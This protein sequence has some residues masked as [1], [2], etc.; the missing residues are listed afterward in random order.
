MKP[1]TLLA[2]LRKRGV[3]LALRGED[4]AWRAPAGTV[5]SELLD[6]VKAGKAGIVA[7]LRAEADA[8]VDSFDRLTQKLEA[9]QQPL[10]HEH[11]FA[12]L[13]EPAKS[14]LLA[15]VGLDVA[16]ERGE[17]C[18]LWDNEGSRYIDFVSQY[19]ALPFGYNPDSVWQAIARVRKSKVPAV[20]TQSLLN[21]AG[22]LAER[23]L[24]L[25]PDGFEHVV[26]CNSGAESIEVAIKVCRA[27]KRRSGVVSA[28]NGFHGLTT[29]ALAATGSPGFQEGFFVRCDDFQSVPFGDSSALD[30]LLGRNPDRFAAFLVEP[31]QGEGGIIVPPAD[32]LKQVREICD[33]HEV[34]LVVDEV[35]T[36]FGRTG[37]MFGF[38]TAGI[39][40]DVIA[41]AKGLGGGLMPSGAVMYHSNAYSNRFALRHSSTFAGNALAASCGLATIDLLT[42]REQDIVSNVRATGGYLHKGLAK[43]QQQFP[44]LVRDVR[45]RGL[46]QA[47][48]FDF[49]S[50]AVGGGLMPILVE[51]EL[52]MYLVVSYLLHQ[53]QIRV[54]PTFTGKNVI[55]LEPAL[56]AGQ[57]EC[58]QLLIGLQK[59]CKILENRSTAKLVANMIPGMKESHGSTP[60]RQGP[61]NGLPIARQS[62][63][64][65]H[66]RA[67][68]D[69][70]ARAPR[71]DSR[72]R[73]NDGAAQT[74]SAPQTVV[75]IAPST[76]RFG[77]LVH[78]SSLE[79]LVRFDPDLAVFS[80]Q[81]L[82]DL[83]QQLARSNEPVEVGTT[84]FFSSLG[85][86]VE[87]QFVLLPWTPAELSNMDQHRSLELISHAAR[88]AAG[89]GVGLVGLGGFTSILSGGGIAIDANGLPPLTSGNSLTA[90]MTIECM[91]QAC[92]A[93]KVNLAEATVA[94]VGATGQTGSA[95]ARLASNCVGRMILVG[96]S[97]QRRTI[98]SLHRIAAEI[99][100][101]HLG[102][103]EHTDQP[104]KFLDS[105]DVA[106]A[107]HQG[108]DEDR[109]PA[110]ADRFLQHS[111]LELSGSIKTIQQ[112]D[113]IL[114]ASSATEPIISSSNVRKNAIVCDASRPAN[115]SAQTI[116]SRPDVMWLEAGLVRIPNCE[117]LDLFAGPYADAAYACVAESALWMLEPSLKQP[118][119]TLSLNLMTIKSLS[120]A[121]AKHGFHCAMIERR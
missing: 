78:L 96:R 80:E 65:S 47:I 45:G 41:L 100:S 102:Q 12:R 16:F 28:R 91:K 108:P 86:S 60:V 58:D 22:E 104:G 103:F 35:Q 106:I 55:R 112:A 13:V 23:L 20:A 43:I 67:G 83:K 21:T 38:E 26:F 7:E 81:Q 53:H 56:I 70:E 49:D 39:V 46:M 75:Q 113:I 48:E 11:P 82:A 44:R 10:S 15:R 4:L 50:L 3:E 64:P 17:G 105:L 107:E 97:E 1:A 95:L 40:P 57:F 54:A 74:A 99:V 118:E 25:A 29:G 36:G 120:E 110:I 59:V 33:R 77:F 117:K 61:E 32:Y 9:D 89:H 63:H 92:A 52:L 24:A 69:P 121:A 68:G 6:Q 34:L 27:A 115:V 14:S 72:L 19:G 111:L 114:A 8:S 90:A 51:Q 37:T 62:A 31:I 94:I 30:D 101:D 66:S 98:N 119:T 109:C 88:I 18:N 5:S 93:R 87:G 2:E 116:A 76:G 85:H 84:T 42:D 79:D 73:G 71:Q